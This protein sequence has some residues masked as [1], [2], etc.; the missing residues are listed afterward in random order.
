MGNT[1]KRGRVKKGKKRELTPGKSPKT[2][3]TLQN[4]LQLAQLRSEKCELGEA[5]VAFLMALKI[6]KRENDFRA[7]MEALAG[8][9]RLAGEALDEE[10]IRQWDRELDAFMSGYPKQIP[11]MAWYCKGAIE[12]H[13]GN[14]RAAQR[15]FH[16]YL[17]AVRKDPKQ[18]TAAQILSG[19]EALVRGWAMLAVILWQRGRIRRAQH[20][21]TEL[22]RRYEEKNY[23]TINGI[24]YLL[25]GNIA[26]K[27]REFETALRW[28]QKAHAS[29]LS[30]HNWFY[31]LYVLYGYARLSRLQQNYS[32]AYWYL[33]LIDKAASGAEFSFLRREIASERSR[34]EQDAVDLLI[35]SRQC[36]IKTRES[37]QISLR[38]QYVLLHILEALSNA[39]GREGDDLERGLSKAEIIEKVWK[40]QYRPEAHD[41]KLYYNINRLR[42][43][44]EPDIR[45]PQYL[46]NWKEGYRLAP[47]LKVQ[48]IGARIQQGREG[49]GGG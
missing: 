13:R 8:L 34:L 40:E 24:L 1:S 39:H 47:G 15:H 22:L 14:T 11:P 16:R 10:S 37:G 7:I 31:H 2:R 3:S 6:G 48:F 23:R 17:R 38:K 9:L 35:D 49:N 18:A 5:R 29:F 28:Y 46:L 32:Q 36:I 27:R 21:A 44:I 30:E 45:K 33:D 20:L 4:W 25:Q 43:L 12:R 41:N 42:K 19:E 26:E